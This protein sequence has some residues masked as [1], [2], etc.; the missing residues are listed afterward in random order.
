MLIGSAFLVKSQGSW[1]NMWEKIYYFSYYGALFPNH[2]VFHV[3]HMS[4]KRNL[5]HHQN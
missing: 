5:L 4:D 1:T 3:H 2:Q